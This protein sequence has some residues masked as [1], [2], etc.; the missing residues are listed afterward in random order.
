M[1]KQKPTKKAKFPAAMMKSRMG[2]KAMHKE[3]DADEMG[4]PSDMD[5]DDMKKMRK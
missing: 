2:M 3:P 4:G 5:M 1:K